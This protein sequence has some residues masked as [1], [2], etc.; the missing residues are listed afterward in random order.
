MIRGNGP[1]MQNAED[2]SVHHV[3]EMVQLNVGGRRYWTLFETLVRSKSSFFSLIM[4]IDN[5]SGKVLLFK[6]NYTVDSEGAIFINRDGDL[7]AHVLQFMRDGKRA[8]LPE[9]IDILKQLIRESEFFGMESWKG[10]LTEQ[11][12]TAERN[13]N[14]IREI[15][16]GIDAH[17]GR[18][19]DS[20]YFNGFKK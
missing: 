9:R 14:E 11:L 15:L 2:I 6:K 19:T 8:V 7:F 10:V 16:A 13:E 1:M 3:T 18:L 17:V 4:R 12:E 20:I 5:I